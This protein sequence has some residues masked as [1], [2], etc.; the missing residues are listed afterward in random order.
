MSNSGSGSSQ[1]G[2]L[3]TV[4]P[5][6]ST[7]VSLL[8][9]MVIGGTIGWY[10]NGEQ[11]LGSVMGGTSLADL[12]DVCQPVVA[13]QKTRLSEIREELTSVQGLV[14]MREAEVADLRAQLEQP[15]IT[16]EAAAELQE[17]LEVAS[18]GLAEAKLEVSSLQRTKDKL[19]DQLAAAQARIEETEADLEAEAAI[20][21]ALQSERSTLVEQAI[22]QRW[23]RM[24]T[25]AQLDIC[26]RGGRRRTEACRAAVVNELK[27]I[28]RQF[29]HCLRSNQAVPSVQEVGRGDRIP[30]HA[31]LLDADDKFL[32]GWYVQ[33]CDPTL[34]ERTLDD[35]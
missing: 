26:E 4:V 9:G 32:S 30:S 3:V 12:R 27:G 15:G 25:E 8:F 23:F 18:I 14:T 16:I 31:K 21:D 34:P 28:R 33:L 20:R 1:L 7:I 5:F 10:A 2:W 19:V 17:Q 22:T 13:E 11:G 35:R 24:I 29:V 6:M